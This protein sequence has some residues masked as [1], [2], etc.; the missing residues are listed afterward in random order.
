[1]RYSGLRIAFMQVRTLKSILITLYLDPWCYRGL[2]NHFEFHP[3]TL[4]SSPLID[5]LGCTPYIP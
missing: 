2:N 5:I 3:L 1:M 4:H